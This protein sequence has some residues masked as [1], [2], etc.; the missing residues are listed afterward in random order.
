MLDVNSSGANPTEYYCVDGSDASSGE[1]AEKK[2]L[3]VI[4]M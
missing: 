2:T 3:G 1:Y 4:G